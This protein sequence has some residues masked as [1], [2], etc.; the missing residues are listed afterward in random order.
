MTV[1]SAALAKEVP[2]GTKRVKGL[3]VTSHSRNWLDCIK[4]GKMPNANFE[5]MRRSHI[6]CHAA[7]LSW[8]LQRKLTFD[9]VKEM[10]VNDD[11]A[12]SLR[13]R[14]QRDPFKA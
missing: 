13:S 1:S 9:P 8:I 11:E 5:V 14:P 4:S 6:A 3:D 2:D 7:A 10:F 12:N